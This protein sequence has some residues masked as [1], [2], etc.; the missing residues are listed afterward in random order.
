M[1]ECIA[2]Q[3]SLINTIEYGQSKLL[4]RIQKDCGLKLAEDYYYD[5]KHHSA[6]LLCDKTCVILDFDLCSID[7]NSEKAFDYSKYC[8]M[9]NAWML[10]SD[11]LFRNKYSL[12]SFSSDKGCISSIF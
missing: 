3:E 1:A 11:R 4:K 9:Q 10:S 8:E 2:S 7:E 12:S 6:V 5:E